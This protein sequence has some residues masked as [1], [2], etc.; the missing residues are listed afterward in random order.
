[1][2]VEARQWAPHGGDRSKAPFGALKTKAE[3]AKEANVG[4][5]SI[6]RAK[7]VSKLTAPDGAVKSREVGF[8]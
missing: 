1:M 5:R 6:D 4:T 8:G 3:L 7:E 2:V